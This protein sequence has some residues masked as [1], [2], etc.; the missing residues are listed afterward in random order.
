MPPRET[1]CFQPVDDKPLFSKANRH[2]LDLPL[3]SFVAI[4][5]IDCRCCGGLREK[6]ET[7]SPIIRAFENDEW[8]L[9]KSTRLNALEDSPDAFGSTFAR[10]SAITDRQWQDRLALLDRSSN[11]PVAA[12]VDDVIVGMAWVERRESTALL[13]QM[14]VDANFRG[15]RVGSKILESAIAWSKSSG[16]TE[17]HLGM[18]VGDSTARRLYESAGF[19]P[20]GDLASIRA[21]SNL[22]MQAMVLRLDTA[23]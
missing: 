16:A 22:M 4:G 3:L 18:T 13:F 8:E 2:L 9:Y 20:V 6:T 14:W 15:L 17:M 23:K 11:F 19:I 5:G 12:F 1:L 7:M 10:A 21:G